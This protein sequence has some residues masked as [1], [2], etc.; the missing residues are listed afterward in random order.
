M[1]LFFKIRYRKFLEKVHDCVTVVIFIGVF[2]SHL[3]VSATYISCGIES[4]NLRVDSC[5]LPLHRVEIPHWDW[6]C[7]TGK[8]LVSES[9]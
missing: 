6:Q 5:L 9:Y 4:E 1:T 7:I 3:Y 2:S 8:I